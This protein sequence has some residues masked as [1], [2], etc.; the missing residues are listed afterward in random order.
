MKF[1][2]IYGRFPISGKDVSAN[3]IQY[4]AQQL[5]VSGDLFSIYD[6]LDIGKRSGGYS[7][8]AL[9]LMLILDN[10]L[11]GCTQSFASGSKSTPRTGR[12]V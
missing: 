6:P 1:M 2:E 9:L 8:I 3:V 4:L 12:F 11:T 5:E 10:F 7:I